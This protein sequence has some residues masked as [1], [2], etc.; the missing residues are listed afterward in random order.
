MLCFKKFYNYKNV[1]YNSL[2]LVNNACKYRAYP[3]ITA[4]IHN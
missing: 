4:E 2:H 3:I 1:I